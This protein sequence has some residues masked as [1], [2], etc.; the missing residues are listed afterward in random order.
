MSFALA[1]ASRY[2]KPSGLA[3]SALPTQWGLVAQGFSLGSPPGVFFLFHGY[4][5]TKAEHI[6]HHD[7]DLPATSPLPTRLQ[8][9]TLHLNALPATGQKALRTT[10]FRRYARPHPRPNYA[11]NKRINS[12]MR[13]IHQRRIFLRCTPTNFRRNLA[14][15]LS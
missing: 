9:R 6:R 11:C 7:L 2:A 12:K 5:P 13:S 3:L 10:W 15:R 4:N 1:V 14:Q 8:R